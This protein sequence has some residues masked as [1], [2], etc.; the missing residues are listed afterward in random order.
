[1][2]AL[3]DS[4]HGCAS[5]TVAGNAV[6]AVPSSETVP[7]SGPALLFVAMTLEDPRILDVLG[8]GD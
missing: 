2:L 6:V 8:I 3:E 1:V 7:T 4:L 5:V